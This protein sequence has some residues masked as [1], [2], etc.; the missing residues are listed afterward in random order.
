MHS[1]S[2]HSHRNRSTDRKLPEVAERPAT[3]PPFCQDDL[4]EEAAFKVFLKRNMRPA[5]PPADLL[6]RI[7]TRIEEIKRD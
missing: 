2:F 3:D 5:N 1:N 7:R 4:S 6:A